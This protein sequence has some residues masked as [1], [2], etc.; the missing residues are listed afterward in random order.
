MDLRRLK[1]TIPYMWKVDR[2]NSKENPTRAT[3]VAYID[4]RIA[5]A[6]L[7]AVCGPENWQNRYENINGVLYC[8]IAIRI[9]GEWIWKSDCGTQSNYEKEKGQASDA[10]KRA[11]VKWGIGAFLYDLP[12]PTVDVVNYKGGKKYY[13]KGA[14]GKPIFDREESSAFIHSKVKNPP[15][16]TS[17]DLLKAC[18]EVSRAGDNN[19]LERLF[20]QYTQYHKDSGFVNLVRAIKSEFVNAKNTAA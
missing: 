11:A 4:A 12:C 5:T 18:M 6:H 14:D 15:T 10:F 16:S 13:V 3:C 19:E 9:D 17:L 20:K 7:D 8:S 1:D 2:Y